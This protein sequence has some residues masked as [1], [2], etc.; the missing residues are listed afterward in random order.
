MAL[1]KIDAANFLTG[2]I[3]S[4]NVANASLSSVTSL[5]AGVGGKVLQVV[6][7]TDSTNRS[8]TSTSYV[9]GSSTLSVNITPSST[10]SKVLIHLSCML[11]IP[12]SFGR[13]TIFRDSTDLAPVG[14]FATTDGNAD[15]YATSGI[16]FLDSP[17]TTSQITYQMRFKSGAGTQTDIA[18]ASALGSITA[19]EIAG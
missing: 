1:S 6:T 8:T 14:G 5:P 18:N 2:T 9:T 4:T 16:H 3:P 12:S 15:Y 19:Y 10:S 11:Y 13:L 17:S 7:A